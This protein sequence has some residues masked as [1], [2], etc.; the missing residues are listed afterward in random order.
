MPKKATIFVS[1]LFVL[2]FPL[3]VQAEGIPL[4]KDVILGAP[5]LSPEDLPDQ[6]TFAIYDSNTALDPL[7][8]QTFARGQYT[9]DFEFSKSDGVTSGN[10]ARVSADF[11]EKLNLVDQLGDP[12]QPKEL[13]AALE[14]AGAQVGERAKVADDALVQLL[15]ASD[16]SIATYL[17]LVYEGDSN[18]IA[19]IYRDLPI[20]SLGSMSGGSSLSDYFS[21]VAAGAVDGTIEPRGLENP[22]NW[23]PTVSV[24]GIAYTYGRVGI[25]TV[26]PETPL[27]FYSPTANNL[28][29]CQS[30][31]NLALIKFA[32]NGTSFTNALGVGADGNNLIFRGGTVAG[33]RE[34][35]RINSIGRI[36]IGTINPGAPLEVFDSSDNN[37][38]LIRSGDARAGFALMDN[39]TSNAST[40]G[41]QA[42]GNNLSLRAGAGDRLYIS[43]SGNIGIGT[44]TPGTHKLAVE[45]TIGCREL[46]V[47]T[48]AWA[49]FVFDENYVLP[50]LDEVE[51]FISKNKHLPG[52]PKEREVKK[53]GFSVGHMNVKLLQKIEELTLYVID[54]KKENDSLRA[55]MADLKA[56][57]GK[58]KP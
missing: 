21:A 11:T 22:N 44:T 12:I 24:N 30:G 49:D 46:T 29:L 14:V 23:Y 40:V 13:W 52:I 2:L 9:I 20:T 38:L 25:G 37:P 54:I 4:Q 48:A 55:Q 58:I 56:K 39:S 10:V 33:G 34:Y 45:G 35:M 27:H 51:A 16:A 8:S 42:D 3:I 53:Q 57:L 15:L 6:I 32:D 31:D 47:T 50:D 5:I 7:G 36:G 26:N 17:T 18:P 43:S 28:M 1:I 19:T 41:V